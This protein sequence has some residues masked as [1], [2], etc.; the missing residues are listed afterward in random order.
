MS[1]TYTTWLAQA[2][3]LAGT[4]TTNP[5]LVTELPG[6]IDYAELRIYRDLDLLATRQTDQ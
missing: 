1:L 5:Y 2:A 4:S 6:A 3:N